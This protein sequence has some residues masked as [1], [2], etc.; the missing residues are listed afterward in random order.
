MP[1]FYQ[2]EL[3]RALVATGQVDLRVV[4]S[5]D[6]PADRTALGCS[7][8]TGA[9]TQRVLPPGR[10]AAV[11]RAAR[12]AWAERDRVHVVNG[13]WAE[14]PF[15]A[16]LAVIAALRGRFA[17]YSEAPTPQVERSWRKRLVREGFGRVVATRR[18][19][20]LL[21]IA[22][23]AERYYQRLGFGPE[24]TYPFAY[25][26]RGA[27]ADELARP[28]STA[29]TLDLVYVGQ[30]IPRKGVDLLLAAIAPLCAEEPRL[31]LTLVG[32]GSSR[33]A[34]ADQAE[35]LG[36]ADR[37]DFAGVVPSEEVRSRIAGADVLVLPSRWDG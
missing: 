32:G 31:R 20:H 25:F 13:I 34:L 17:I 28:S 22:G 15:A 18:G 4:F 35:V 3:Y 24:R 30:L 6:L 36:I 12:I 11:V 9:Y 2:D 29:A 26:R 7:S 10:A 14:P 27:T 1:S 5:R 33:A 37:V 19:A 16:A 8:E 21:P 23:F